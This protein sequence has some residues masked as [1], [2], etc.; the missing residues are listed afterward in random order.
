MRA[1]LANSGFETYATSVG[2]RGF[3]VLVPAHGSQLET[4]EGGVELSAVPQ[5]KRFEQAPTE[6]L[7]RWAEE[8]GVWVCA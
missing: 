7:G 3:G 6:E 5:Q 4:A 2:G 1:A 8:A